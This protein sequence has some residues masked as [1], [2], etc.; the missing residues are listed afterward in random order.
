M[1]IKPYKETLEDKPHVHLL[2]T[3]PSKEAAL[4]VQQFINVA[5]HGRMGLWDCPFI[6]MFV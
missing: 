6:F 5:K 3:T 2:R 4:S 1:S